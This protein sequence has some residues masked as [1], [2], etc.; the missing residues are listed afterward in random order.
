MT[1]DVEVRHS[2]FVIRHRPPAYICT[3][4]TAPGVSSVELWPSVRKATSWPAKPGDVTVWC[5]RVTGTAWPN[6]PSAGSFHW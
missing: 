4:T 6:S 3:V 1:N 5:G 2:P